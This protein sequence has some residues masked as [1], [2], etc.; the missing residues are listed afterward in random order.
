M[1][2]KRP[3]EKSAPVGVP[4]STRYR[5]FRWTVLFLSLSALFVQNDVA[6]IWPGAE[7]QAFWQSVDGQSSDYVLEIVR[8]NF[9]QDA[10]WVFWPRLVSSLLLIIAF[11]TWYAI[12]RPLFGQDTVETATLIA[13]ASLFLPVFGKVGSGD[14]G[15]FL[16]HLGIWLSFLR[17]QKSGQ[18]PWLF[19]LL[20]LAFLA[21]FLLPS[22]TLVL[23]ASLLL[24]SRFLTKQVPTLSFLAL[25][26]AGL[27]A[28]IG[29]LGQN[30]TISHSWF[31]WSPLAGSLAPLRLLGF[32]LLGVL[33]FIGFSL[34]SLRDLVYKVR[35]GEELSRIILVATVAAIL[36]ASPILPF[37]LIVLTS[38]QLISYYRPNYPWENWVKGTAVLHLVF[39]FIASVF[40]LLGLFAELRGPGF[41]AALGW[42]SAYW[43]FSLIAVIGLYGRRRDYVFGGMMLAGALSVLFFWVQ[44]YPYVELDRAWPQQLVSRLDNLD[45]DKE[46]TI[47]L[48]SSNT[49]LPAAPYLKR[50]GRAVEIGIPQAPEG[51]ILQPL[52]T[53]SQ[54]V[55]LDTIRG[56]SIFQLQGWVLR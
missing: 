32:S 15:L 42:V 13:A 41:R 35:R 53:I 55:A 33:P 50:A 10:Y 8:S 52:G 18:R 37:L 27:G 1:S 54:Q 11:A 19:L 40:L 46:T 39:A 30:W 16:L 38:K 7:A 34:A 51:F 28:L 47:Y 36:A 22:G 5:F 20:L 14:A 45:S 24:G 21:A 23:V 9:P 49:T 44:V 4:A 26:M 2:Q 17:F 6:T 48:E 29:G 3:I 12:G 56:R 25:L 31:Y 43:M